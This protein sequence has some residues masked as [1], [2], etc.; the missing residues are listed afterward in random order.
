MSARTASSIAMEKGVTGIMIAPG[1]EGGPLLWPETLNQRTRNQIPAV[2]QHEKD[3]LERQRDDAWRQA[4]HAHRH[5][6]RGDHDVDDKKRQE[7]QEADFE[8]APEL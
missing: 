2:D 5:D 3:Q 6:Q 7:Q 1:A 4:D 8:G